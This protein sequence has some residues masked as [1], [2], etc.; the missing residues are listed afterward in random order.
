MDMENGKTKS[1]SDILILDIPVIDDQHRSFWEIYDNVRSLVNDK[2]IEKDRIAGIIE[3]LTHYLE[4]H[5][6]TEE[7]LMQYSDS[8]DIEG[9]IA[10]HDF[11]RTKINEFVLGMQ[12]GNRYLLT[13]MLDFVKKWFLFHILNTDTKYKD[14]VKSYLEKKSSGL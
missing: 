1:W 10:E 6:K 5:F 9:H 4:T 8:Q 14:S 12:Y 11:F 13:A 2:N 7:Q 3:E